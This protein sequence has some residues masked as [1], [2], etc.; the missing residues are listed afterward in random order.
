MFEKLIIIMITTN[1][2]ANGLLLKCRG[3]LECGLDDF[4]I[5]GIS[6]YNGKNR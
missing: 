4:Q 3:D 2:Q 1:L 5:T 6:I